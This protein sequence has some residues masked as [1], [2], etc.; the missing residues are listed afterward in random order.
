MSEWGM[1][2]GSLAQGKGTG[3]TEDGIV[4]LH[5]KL[6]RYLFDTHLRAY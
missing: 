6:L 1:V 3:R 4:E 5:V 2:F